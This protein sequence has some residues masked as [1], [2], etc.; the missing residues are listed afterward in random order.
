[1]G[2]LS[3]SFEK[4][5]LEGWFLEAMLG[6]KV[7]GGWFGWLVVFWCCQESK[8][9]LQ[10]KRE[11]KLRTGDSFNSHLENAI[12]CGNKCRP[13]RPTECPSRRCRIWFL[14]LPMVFMKGMSQS[15]ILGKCI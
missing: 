2:P 5:R 13:S 9:Y 10:F 14:G 7:V 11:A 12:K 4:E 1:M 6:E 3:K 15:E 8:D